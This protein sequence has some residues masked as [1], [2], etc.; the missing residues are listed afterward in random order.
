MDYFISN[1]LYE[2][3]GAQSHYTE[4]LF[5]LH[6]LPT[7]A[8]Y[9]RPPAP[10]PAPDRSVFG[11]HP[12]DHVYLCPQSL[13]KLHPDFDPLLAAIIARDPRAIVVLLGAQYEDHTLQLSARLKRSL[14]EAARR[15]LILDR[16]PYARYMQLLSIGDVCLDTI[17]FNGMNTSLEALSVGLPVVTL[18]GSLQRGRHTQA[19]LRKLGIADCIAHSA[20][21]YVDIA[22][23]LACD[24]QFARSVRERI[25]ERAGVLYEDP[26]V[27]R[28]FARFFVTALREKRPEIAW[29]QPR[30]TA[31]DDTAHAVE[32]ATH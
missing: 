5:E 15:I 27:L 1:D 26:R 7:L 13:F 10:E 19:M 31:Q 11:L 8:Y 12:E 17:C 21:G 23:R 24:A 32:H 9:Q 20:Q 3:A 4:R 28:E 30:G 18:P 14:G 2:P 25:R 22:V 29:P 6:D 16:M